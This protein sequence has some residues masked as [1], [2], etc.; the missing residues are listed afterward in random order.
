MVQVHVLPS[1]R[2]RAKRALGKLEFLQ[3]CSSHAL[4]TAPAMHIKFGH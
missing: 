4:P 1:V 3:I 2:L